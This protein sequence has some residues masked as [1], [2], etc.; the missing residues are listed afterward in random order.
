MQEGV[1]G[2]ERTGW[3][4]QLG[5]GKGGRKINGYNIK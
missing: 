2:R 1:R 5:R 4:E 3:G